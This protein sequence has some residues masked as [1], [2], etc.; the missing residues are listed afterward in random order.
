[1]EI[2]LYFC[3]SYGAPLWFENNAQGGVLRGYERFER[4]TKSFRKE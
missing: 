3:M 2:K 4:L 1:M